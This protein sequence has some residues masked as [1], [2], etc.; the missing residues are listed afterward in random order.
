MSRYVIQSAYT[1]CFL[2]PSHGDGQPEWVMFL[3][4][5]C[6]VHDLESCAQIIEDH[7]DAFHR[8]VVVDLNEL[9][10]VLPD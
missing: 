7:A 3:R 4:D 6:V 8:A 5:A 2:A 9:H 1:G 10:S